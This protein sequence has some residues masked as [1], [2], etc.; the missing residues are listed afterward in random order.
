MKKD[1][2]G[3][4]TKGRAGFNMKLEEEYTGNTKEKTG[5]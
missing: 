5:V 1:T 3:W 2:V 4:S